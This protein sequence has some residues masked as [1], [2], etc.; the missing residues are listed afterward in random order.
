MT[1]DEEQ[2]AFYRALGFAIAQWAHVE[3]SLHVTYLCALGLYDRKAD[4]SLS[5]TAAFYSAISA[6]TKVAMTNSAV[7]FELLRRKSDE[8]SA[9]HIEW[10]ALHKKTQRRQ[11]IRN[12]LAHF[13]VLITMDKKEG[14]RW[15]L[16]PRLFDANNLVRY[17]EKKPSR[18]YVSDLECIGNSFGALSQK[19]SV[20]GE[21]L[22]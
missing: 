3:D 20:F 12:K 17:R 15:E 18:F 14:R 1:E 11:Q 10:K 4:R 19:L 22:Q 13:Q 16:R 7:I 5:A 2:T 6:E 21:T 9:S 8:K